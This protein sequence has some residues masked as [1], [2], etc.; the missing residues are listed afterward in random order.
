MGKISKEYLTLQPSFKDNKG[1]TQD[2]TLWSA[3]L[4]EICLRHYIE[5]WE[6][7]K[8]DVNRYNKRTDPP[9]KKNTL[10][11]SEHFTPYET[12]SDP[13]TTTSSQKTSTYTLRNHQRTH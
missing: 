8:K 5:L 10:Q 6:Q 7:Q 3:T 9:R 13:Q 1:N 2:L 11:T 12:S 4:I